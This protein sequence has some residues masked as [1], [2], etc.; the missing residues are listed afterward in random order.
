MFR[1]KN[2]RHYKTTLLGIV[3]VAASIAYPFFQ[4]ANP[5]IFGILIFFGLALLFMPDTLL[6]S[7][8]KVLESNSDKKF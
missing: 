6:T 2:L 8:K 5:W 1:L 3:I 4:D 7:L